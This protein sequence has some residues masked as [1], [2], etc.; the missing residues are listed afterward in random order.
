MQPDT[1]GPHRPSAA[2]IH[3]GARG[4]AM[5]DGRKLLFER[6]VPPAARRELLRQADLLGADYGLLERLAAYP[7][8]D[9]LPAPARGAEDAI[10]AW[11]CGAAHLASKWR[12]DKP[13]W[14]NPPA[15]SAAIHADYLLDAM[16]EEASTDANAGGRWRKLWPGDSQITLESAMAF[17]DHLSAFYRRL[18]AENK[19][20][21]SAVHFP[22]PTKAHAANARRGI[23]VRLLSARFQQN[24]GQPCDDIVA[25]LYCAAFD[26]P[27]GD[28]SAETVR[29]LRRSISSGSL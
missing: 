15:E 21:W 27:E 23:F 16:K 13:V 22:E 20:M 6:W 26:D 7:A 5:A 29:A 25:L 18:D 12:P 11:V 2:T 1:A 19:Q 24:F 8:W 4:G 14:W 9:K 28:T 10:I 3:A 17:V